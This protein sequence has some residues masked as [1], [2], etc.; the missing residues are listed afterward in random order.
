M[1]IDASIY[2][3]LSQ[4][5]KSALDYA[6]E[7][8]QRGQANQMNALQL[9]SA[10][11]QA[12]QAQQSMADDQALR[13]YLSGGADISTPEGQ[14]GLYKVAPTKAGGILKDRL[15]LAKDQASIA[16]DTADTQAKQYD[17]TRK[18]YEHGIMSVVNGASPD[19]IRQSV[20]DGVK[21]GVYSMQEATQI[22]SDMPTDPGQLQQ[23]KLA[24]LQHLLPAKD[25]LDQQLKQR[26]FGLKA[27][28]DIMTPDGQ[29]GFKPNQPYIDAKKQVAKSGAPNVSVNTG[30]KGYE[31]E[32]K[33]RNDFKS[34]PIYKDFN[35]MKSAHAQITSALKQESP[36][37]DTAAATKIMKLLDPGSVV[38]ESELGMA[39]AAAGKMDRLQNMVQMWAN[40]QKLTPT[41]RKD[42]KSLADELFDAA[43]QAYNS[44][45]SE[46]AKFGKGYGLN[47]DVLGGP[48]VSPKPTA[49]GHTDLGGGFKLKGK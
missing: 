49:D 22:L 43:G 10:Q 19:A 21:Q 31:N 17:L 32:S 14:S 26:E 28:N 45:R 48:A 40:G 8:Q 3:A 24:Q 25:A 41:Q 30:Q 38:R 7:F 34:E 5:R 18:K 39:M 29:G 4:P 1:P 33:L 6:D 46:Y 15:G 11:L 35:D 2:N 27:A 9:Q 12:Q 47:E 37:A 13:R 20:S 44:K 36:I 42:F 23:W 16:K